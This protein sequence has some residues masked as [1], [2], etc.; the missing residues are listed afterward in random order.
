MLTR[1]A[2][3]G[4]RPVAPPYRFGMWTIE[5]LNGA[6]ERWE[7]VRGG[8]HEVFMTK[9]AWCVARAAAARARL[10][11]CG[12]AGAVRGGLRCRCGAHAVCGSLARALRLAGTRCSTTTAASST[13]VSDGCPR[14]LATAAAQRP[15]RRRPPRLRGCWA[16]WSSLTAR[17]VTAAASSVRDAAAVA[18]Q[19]VRRRRPG[20]GVRLR[21]VRCAPRACAGPARKLEGIR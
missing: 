21:G 15:S 12:C 6:L 18:V 13:A 3:A 9:R 5:G 19:Q 4:L 14:P 16:H 2:P 10:R 8:E 7:K 17:C 1:R 20:Q 11:L